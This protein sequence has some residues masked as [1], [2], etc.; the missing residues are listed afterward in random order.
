MRDGASLCLEVGF[1]I[2]CLIMDAH[3]PMCPTTYFICWNVGWFRGLDSLT[4]IYF[5]LKFPPILSWI[6]PFAAPKKTLSN[7]LISDTY[8]YLPQQNLQQQNL[9]KKTPKH[10]NINVFNV[11]FSQTFSP[12]KDVAMSSPFHRSKLHLNH[13]SIKTRGT[14]WIGCMGH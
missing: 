3:K 12:K 14:C 10:L 9:K 1:G 2:Y 13:I 6:P 4:L 5:I 7:S 11:D 8:W